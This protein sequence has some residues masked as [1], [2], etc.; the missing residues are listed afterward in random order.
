MIWPWH[1]TTCENCGAVV[2]KRRAHHLRTVFIKRPSSAKT[3]TAYLNGL[4]APD[5][6]SFV[7]AFCPTCATKWPLMGT[8]VQL[9]FED[10]LRDARPLYFK[11]DGE[12]VGAH[13]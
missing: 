10:A 1:Y 6:I 8:A 3:T 13:D 4:E 2:E 5:V 9:V 12:P 11:R 7:R